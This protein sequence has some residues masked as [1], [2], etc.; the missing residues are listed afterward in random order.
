MSVTAAGGFVAAAGAVGIKAGEGPDLAVVA[1]ADGRPVP[2]A[3]VFTSN[4]AAAAPVRSSR[5]HLDRTGGRA[6][7]VLLT[8]GNANAAT[9]RPGHEAVETLCR[10][11]ADEIGSLPEEVLACQ[12]GLIGVPFPLEGVGPRVAGVV[13]RRA[14]GAAAGEAA[15]SAIMTTDTVRKEAV[16]RGTGPGGAAFTVGGMAKGAAMLAPDMATMLAVLTTDAAADP[17]TLQLVLAGAVGRTFNEMT[18][19]G[20]TS[21]NDTVLLLASGTAGPVGEDALATAV[22]DVCA[23]LSEQ[24]AA[25]AEGATKL[26][27]VRVTGA[28]SDAEAHRAARKVAGSLLVKCSLNGEDPYWG[29]VVS[30][31]GSAGVEFDLDQVAVRYGGVAVCVGGTAADHDVAAVATHMKGRTIELHCELGLGPGAGAVTAT[32]LGYGYLDENR[33]TS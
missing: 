25:D 7:A 13:A 1:T 32:D 20:C 11:V 4:R 6:A 12:T 5:D 23:S 22:A 8:S 15:A 10:L 21:T 16:A 26:A 19:D 30:E 3:G 17:A 31:L 29:R 33:T 27:H 18:V 9:G 2:A 14:A 28:A 24:M